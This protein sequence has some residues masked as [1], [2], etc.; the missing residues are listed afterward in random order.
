M[1]QYAAIGL[2]L[3]KETM[4]SYQIVSYENTEIMISVNYHEILVS[5]Y[6]EDY[7]TPKYVKTNEE[8]VH[9]LRRVL[10]KRD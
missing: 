1:D 4:M 7:M 5:S 3:P 10:L 9:A 2:I 8:D 6:G